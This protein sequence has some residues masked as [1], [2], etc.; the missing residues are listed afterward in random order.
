M[1]YPRMLWIILNDKLQKSYWLMAKI[2]GKVG[3]YL[4]GPSST[5]S[6][7]KESTPD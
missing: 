4:H 6:M 1:G 5:P 3:K 7:A 2:D